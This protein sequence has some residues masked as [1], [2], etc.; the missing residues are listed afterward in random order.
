MCLVWVLN[1]L[2]DT[3]SWPRDLRPAE[4]G[5]QQSEHVH[6][7]R[8]QARR[9]GGPRSRLARSDAER[10]RSD[11]RPKQSGPSSSP[12]SRNRRTKPAG[13]PSASA[14]ADVRQ[15]LLV[16]D[17]ALGEQARGPGGSR[18]RC[19]R[20][21]GR[22][23]AGGR[24]EPTAEHAS[25]AGDQQAGERELV[26]LVQIRGYRPRTVPRAQS[27]ASSRLPWAMRTLARAAAIG[28]T[29]GKKPGR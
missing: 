22:P 13:T 29:S 28:R 3:Y 20:C 16:L 7:A 8:A 17:H 1:V 4:V 26:V 2:S 18:R 11:S 27:E 9:G 24:A 15:R 6:L 25:R 14:L 21:P 12:S 10:T 19:A 5:R 23:P